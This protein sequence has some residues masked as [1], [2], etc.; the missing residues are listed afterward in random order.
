MKENFDFGN[1]GDDTLGS[2]PAEAQL[3]GFRTFAADFYQVQ[4]ASKDQV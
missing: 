1:P 4:R 2:W 3:P